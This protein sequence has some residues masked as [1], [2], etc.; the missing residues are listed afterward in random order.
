MNYRVK[1]KIYFY[2]NI[3]LHCIAATFFFFAALKSRCLDFMPPDSYHLFPFLQLSLYSPTIMAQSE[4]YRQFTLQQALRYKEEMPERAGPEA[5]LLLLV[6]LH[7]PLL[8]LGPDQDDPPGHLLLLDRATRLL[9]H[10]DVFLHAGKHRQSFI[11]E[12]CFTFCNEV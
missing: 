11:E 1:P 12:F 3:A 9:Q 7:A 8:D 10:L 5:A 4:V 2:V 6:C